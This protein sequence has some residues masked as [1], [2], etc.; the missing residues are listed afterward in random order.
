MWSNSSFHLGKYLEMYFSRKMGLGLAIGCSALL[1]KIT[2]LHL[3]KSGCLFPFIVMCLFL[4]E[5]SLSLLHVSVVF[6]S[7]F[8]HQSPFYLEIAQIPGPGRQQP[9]P[10]CKVLWRA[11]FPTESFF[12]VSV[13]ENENVIALIG[14]CH[15]HGMGP[16]VY[17]L[18][19]GRANVEKC[20]FPVCL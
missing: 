13:P 20:S 10:F 12:W 18:L 4:P 11:F 7:F 2:H 14:C 1:R 9:P 16:R 19:F 3:F 5:P 6:D 15:W 17:A 8:L